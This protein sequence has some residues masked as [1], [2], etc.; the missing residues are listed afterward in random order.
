MVFKLSE[1][2]NS[3]GQVDSVIDRRSEVLRFK[4][5]QVRRNLLQNVIP[6]EYFFFTSY[7]G[8]VLDRMD[9]GSI[10]ERIQRGLV[11]PAS[12]ARQVARPDPAGCPNPRRNWV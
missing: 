6:G 4:S 12:L 11:Q 8:T 9:A 10:P 7:T 5:R 1:D 3:H 2:V